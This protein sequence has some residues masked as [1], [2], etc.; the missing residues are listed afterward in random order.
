MDLRRILLWPVYRLAEWVDDNP[1]SAIGLLVASGSIAALLASTV[2][3]VEG[4][5]DSLTLDATTAEL[6]LDAAIERP[7]YPITALIGIAVVI[8]YKG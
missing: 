3:G 6:V 7:A 4:G 2:F 8:F 1:V 5:A